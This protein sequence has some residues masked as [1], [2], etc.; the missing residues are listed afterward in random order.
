MDPDLLVILS[1]IIAFT[2]AFESVVVVYL[3]NL[4]FFSMCPLGVIIPLTECHCLIVV[5]GNFKTVHE[6][7]FCS[8]GVELGLV[9][10]ANDSLLCLSQLLESG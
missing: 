4:N 10:P 6:D 2:F 3:Y 9:G 7:G 1:G 8:K 5:T